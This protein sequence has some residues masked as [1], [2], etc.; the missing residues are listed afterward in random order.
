MVGQGLDLQRVR[1]LG[2]GLEHLVAADPGGRVGDRA[3]GQADAGQDG[4]RHEGVP[5][6]AQA[7]GDAGGGRRVR[8][9]TV[10]QGGHHGLLHECRAA[11]R[12]W[13]EWTGRGVPSGR[14]S[15]ATFAAVRHHPAGTCLDVV[16]SWSGRP[17]DLL[18]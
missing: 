2:V 4:Q 3:D 14:D 7:C 8:G 17:G 13:D 11:V 5:A 18:E 15:G 9:L 16:V 12:P 6:D 1:V 10:G